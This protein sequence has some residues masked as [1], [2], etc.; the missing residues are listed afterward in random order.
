MIEKTEAQKKTE[1]LLLAGLKARRAREKRFVWLGRAAITIALFFLAVLFISIG[2]KGIPGFFQH[3]VTLEVSLDRARLD[4]AGDMSDQSF[5]DGQ[6]KKLVYEAIYAELDITG[7]TP[8]K[9]ARKLLSNG[10]DVR[11]VEFVKA[12]PD[13]L[14]SVHPVKLALDDD[15][16]SYLR[17]FIDKERFRM[18]VFELVDIWCD[19]ISA[20]AYTKLCNKIF[21]MVKELQ[22]KT[23]KKKPKTAAQ[24]R[25]KA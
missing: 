7:R 14:D 22:P 16:D 25:Q 1:S 17:G 10:S 20:D 11:L 9:M 6:A 23:K 2:S 24:P 5:F 12:N 3:Y 21:H 8:K 4:P 19:E 18:C 13:L 15:A